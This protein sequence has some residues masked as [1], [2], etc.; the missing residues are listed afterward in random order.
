MIAVVSKL[1]VLLLS[2]T[3]LLFGCKSSV[4]RTSPTL[5]TIHPYTINDQDSLKTTTYNRDKSLRLDLTQVQKTGDPAS[6]FIYKVYRATD[7]K[8]IKEGSFRGQL[9]GWN[10]ATS[11]KL[12]PYIGIEQQPVS[13]NPED[14]LNAKNNTQSH[15][16]ILKLDSL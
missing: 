9:V 4:K 13:E 6:H 16:L 7:Q 10:D 5:A 3:F 15:I 1:F 14:L 2:S 8:L 11:L 12:V